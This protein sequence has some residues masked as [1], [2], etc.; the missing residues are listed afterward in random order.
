[1][2]KCFL[3]WVRKKTGITLATDFRHSSWA[4]AMIGDAPKLS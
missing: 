1:M 3:F 2:E 4:R